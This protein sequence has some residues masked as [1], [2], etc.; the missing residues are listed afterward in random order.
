M[1]F[2]LNKIAKVGNSVISTVKKYSP[3]ILMVTGVALGGVAAYKAYKAAPKVEDVLDQVEEA[4]A[5]GIEIPKAV[6]AIDISKQLAPAIITGVG[7]IACVVGSYKIQKNRIIGL[8]SAVGMLTAE[9]KYQRDKYL[10]EHGEEQFKKFFGPTEKK[11]V[12]TVNELGTHVQVVE[13]VQRPTNHLDGAWFSLSDQYVSDDHEYNEMFVKQQITRIDLRKF[14]KNHILVNEVLDLFG[15]SK[16]KA[17]AIFGWASDSLQIEAETIYVY[18]EIT[19]VK[20]PQIY[21]HWNM[22]VDISLDVDYANE[23]DI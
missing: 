5:E 9:V 2:N 16:T 17:G 19:G 8:S 11:K 14:K 4:Q 13:E 20:V 22:P 23:Y 15:L 12:D 3:E 18:N 1:K 10:R 7:A 21:I 6:I